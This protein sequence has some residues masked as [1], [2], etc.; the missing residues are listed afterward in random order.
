[1]LTM[2]KSIMKQFGMGDGA[3]PIPKIDPQM[4]SI[5]CQSGEVVLVDVREPDEWEATG[6]PKG[7]AQIALQ[8]PLFVE[9][10]LSCV[11]NKKDTSIILCCKSG[12]RGEKAGQLLRARGFENI[13]NIDGGMVRWLEE[14]LPTN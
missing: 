2:F 8:N 9:D 14:N 12:M 1:M 4:A 6:S 10:V 5:K 3:S 11:D 7:S 13:V